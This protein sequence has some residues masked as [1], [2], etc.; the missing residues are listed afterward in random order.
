MSGDLKLTCHPFEDVQHV[1][2]RAPLPHDRWWAHSTSP[3]LHRRSSPP[4]LPSPP[5]QTP[6]TKPPP[7]A[8]V[9]IRQLWEWGRLITNIVRL[10]FLYFESVS[11]ESE[12]RVV[13]LQFNV[14]RPIHYN[15]WNDHWYADLNYRFHW[16]YYINID[17]LIPKTVTTIKKMKTIMKNK[18]KQTSK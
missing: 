9:F 1:H 16:Y 4:C 15:L 6:A 10:W 17:C 14:D 12:D 5:P 18:L 2:W 13:E 11:Q 3:T 7:S 8:A